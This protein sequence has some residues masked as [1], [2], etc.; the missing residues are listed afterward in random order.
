MELRS[1]WKCA[2]T[3]LKKKKTKDLSWKVEEDSFKLGNFDVVSRL[4]KEISELYDK[5]ERMWHQRSWLQW[6]Q[7]DDQNTKLFHD[8][9][10]QRK[11]RNFIKG[12]QD[13][14]GVWL[15]DEEV[16]LGM[17]T[18]FYANLFTSSN[19]HDFERILDGVQTVV[20]EEM[21]ADLAKPYTV[22]EVNF[23]FKEM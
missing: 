5:K 4:K 18:E 13:G 17:L 8:T 9:T 23:A 7:S 22:E 14:N 3:N 16:F 11:R 20:T 2:E 6:L 15:E 21:K 12:L 19:P 10:T 1:F